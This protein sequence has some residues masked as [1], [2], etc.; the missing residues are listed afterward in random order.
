MRITWVTRS[1]L[2]YRI[3]LYQAVD[4]LCGGQL[5]VIYYKD[6]VPERCRLKVKAILGNRAIALSGEWRLT[7][8][9]IQPISA[10]K[11]QGMR[12][13][14]Q[15]GLTKAITDS[16]PDVMISDGFFQ[17]TYAPLW[18]RFWE[19]T[20]HIMCYEGTLH[21]EKNAGI[22]RTIYRKIANNAID[23]ILCNGSLSKAYLHQLGVSDD[24]ITEGNMIAD[25]EAQTAGG[26]PFSSAI[27]LKRKQELGL[28]E[29]VFLYLGR[30]V[31][32]KG[33]RQMIQA[34][35]ATMATY[36]NVS[37]LIVG[38]GP[39]KNQIMQMIEKSG[40]KNIVLT[41][42][43]DYGEVPEYL[44]ITDVFLMPTLQDNWSLVIPEAM[45]FGLP[46][47][48]SS[49]NGCWPEL[50]QASNGWV[51]DPL[52]DENFQ[53]TL[54]IAWDKKESWAG[55]GVAS[56]TII[57]AYTPMRVAKNLLEISQKLADR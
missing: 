12:I 14:F 47:I 5:T 40:C 53:S 16:N 35:I 34:W 54:R 52:N 30:L 11:G 4:T 29:N 10:V 41:G 42:K 1:F 45:S 46:I 9:K 51:F 36:N 6:V 43:V 28:N 38:D 21:T 19:K 13:P 22:F 33:I 3:P 32:I 39:E 26:V 44:E 37:L 57:S 25:L 55:M 17:W 49:Y 50:V 27:K 48:C 31:P 8:K 20:P 23:H 15:P 56:K 24:K 18:L 2:D 7:G